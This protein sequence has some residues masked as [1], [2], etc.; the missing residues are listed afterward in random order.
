MAT[1]VTWVL[2]GNSK[3]EISSKDH[4]VQLMNAGTLYTNAGSVPTDFYDSDYIQ[5][6]DIDLQSDSNIVPLGNATDKFTGSYDGANFAISNWSYTDPEFS[7]ANDCANYVGFFA[8]A[9]TADIKNMRLTGVCTL[10]G[11][12]IGG[13]IFAGWLNN[14]TTANIELDLS[15]GSGINQGDVTFSWAYIGT[16]IG[17]ISSGSAF[18]L[19]LNGEMTNMIPSPNTGNPV[20]SGMI[21]YASS[22]TVTLVRNLAMFPNGLLNGYYVGGVIGY[23]IRGSSSLLINVMEGNMSTNDQYVGGVIGVARIDQENSYIV[24]GLVNSMKGDIIANNTAGT[25]G[26]VL[27]NM[28]QSSTTGNTFESFLNYMS[29][30]IIHTPGS[31]NKTGGILGRADAN[32]VLSTSIN[33]MNGYVYNTV[34]GSATGTEVSLATVDTNFGLTFDVDTWSTSSPVTGLPTDSN[35]FNLPYVALTGTDA[36]GLTYN[37]DFVFGN[38]KSLQLTARPLNIIV[39]ID[40]VAGATAYRVTVQRTSGNTSI[41]EV[42]TGFTGTEVNIN[43]LRPGTEYN[44]IL[45]ATSDGTQ[46]NLELEGTI[47]TLANSAGNYDIN[48]FD[49][50]NGGYN[51]SDLDE[52]ARQDLYGVINDLFATG[53]SLTI[54]VGSIEKEA[55]FVKRGGTTSIVGEDA[56]LVPFDPTAGT[57]Q[58]VSLTLSDTSTAVVNFDETVET[59]SVGGQ[60]Y[61][62]GQYTILDGKKVLFQDV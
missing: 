39:T 28:W 59:V 54:D 47:T 42:V 60:T 33:A 49:D 57:S 2:D 45:F 38:E 9:Q 14:C 29:G 51:L 41:R 34:I 10:N 3:Y 44:V 1:T 17:F 26:G 12:K 24:S 40:P 15:P 16:M 32:P 36:F 11:F 37:W 43:S 61:N 19:T 53:D 50:S 52:L 20:L 21:G 48:D 23:L 22:T 4:L 18:G 58:T 56:V 13:G 30:D 7:T 25:A 27:G 5:T 8:E 6:V 46:Y 35:Y 31:I 62:L 55:K